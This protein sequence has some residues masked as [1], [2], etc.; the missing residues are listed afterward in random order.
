M[1]RLR[2]RGASPAG[3]CGSSAPAIDAEPEPDEEILAKS[4]QAD[5]VN[6]YRAYGVPVFNLAQARRTKNTP[7]LPDL[8]V[9]SE[10]VRS[11]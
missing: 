11:G 3:V 8:W 10:R 9:F 5:V 1:A 4:E 6:L 7:G 2:G